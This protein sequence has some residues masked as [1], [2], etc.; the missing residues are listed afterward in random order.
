[1]RDNVR[2]TN[3]TMRDFYKRVKPD[4]F[5]FMAL[6]GL[7]FWNNG[8]EVAL[9]SE[10]L[11]EATDRNRAQI[12]QELNIVYKKRGIADYATR[13]GDLLCLLDIMENDILKNAEDIEVF[14]LHNLFNE[15]YEHGRNFSEL[16]K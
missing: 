8:R 1:M 4:N 13:L 9:Q 10:H 7:S 2:R 5:E 15:A 3:A 12:L 6:L 11:S 14:R 16:G